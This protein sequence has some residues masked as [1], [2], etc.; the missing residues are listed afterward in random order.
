M[1][2]PPRRLEVAGLVDDP[3]H[4]L[5]E[6][7]GVAVDEGAGAGGGGG[8]G[9]SGAA[10]SGR[11]AAAR[12]V[13]AEVAGGP[14]TAKV[15]LEVTVTGTEEAVDKEHRP[16]RGGGGAGGLE[17]RRDAAG[18]EGDGAGGVRD[19][20]EDLVDV[21]VI[22]AAAGAPLDGSFDGCEES[23]VRDRGGRGGGGF[24]GRVVHDRP[25]CCPNLALE[26]LHVLVDALMCHESSEREWSTRVRC[27]MRVIASDSPPSCE[28]THL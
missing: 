22:V 18:E 24:V 11:A 12:S 16:K 17:A 4:A 23:P 15:L 8:G 2:G 13:D 9:A 27:C 10:E 5:L 3:L 7:G 21:P 19:E 26:H 1:V 6:V 25:D 14:E 20:E 28:Y